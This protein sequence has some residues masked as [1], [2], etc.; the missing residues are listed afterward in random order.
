MAR[1]RPY[2][3]A[4]CNS[5]TPS[6]FIVRKIRRRLEGP[7]SL[8]VAELQSLLR[9]EWRLAKGFLGLAKNVAAMPAKK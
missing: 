9:G 4:P 3:W 5:L 2:Y 7:R 6:R 8:A 1:W